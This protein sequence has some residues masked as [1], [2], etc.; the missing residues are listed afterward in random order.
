[1]KRILALILILAF[2]APRFQARAQTDITVKVNNAY[3]DYP[4]SVNFYITVATSQELIHQI[5][6]FYGTDGRSC[7]ASLGRQK[8]DFEPGKSVR[9]HW[10]WDLLKSG[11]LPPGVEVWWQWEIKYGDVEPLL[12]ERKSL[13]IEDTTFDWKTVSNDQVS[14]YWADGSQQFGQNL[15]YIATRSLDRL[16]QE[17]GIAPQ[18]Q[19]RLTI[20]PT[21]DDLHYA[22]LAAPEWTGGVAF[23]EYGSILI[24]IPVDSGSWAAEV[25]PHELAHLVTGEM[26]FNCLGIH[27]PTWLE[28]GLAVY[29]EGSPDVLAVEQINERAVAGKLPSLRSLAG[30]FPANSESAELAYIQSGEVVRFMIET[31]G[32]EKMAALLEALKSGNVIDESLVKVYGL[33]T[34]GIDHVWLVSIGA[35]DE[36]QLVQ[37]SPTFQATQVPT[38]A[39]WT[40]AYNRPTHTFTP[41]PSRTHT[42]IP[43]FTPTPNEPIST[44]AQAK[45][46]PGDLKDTPLRPLSCLGNTGFATAIFL[47]LLL[48]PKLIRKSSH[49]TPH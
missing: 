17:A 14:V 6:L 42:P 39:L 36:A 13:L 28:E 44:S 8:M 16:S 47:S 46:D 37:A 43:S 25:I 2:I 38:L 7:N 31:Y 24:G 48:T 22:I 49:Q 27:T 18:E 3:S 10:E 41:L 33:D 30:G 20:Y 15:L 26:T 19:V 9:L 1:M 4:T 32:A 45:N 23:P 21:F 5:T 11:N 29:S 35:A 40:Q 34:D 12:T